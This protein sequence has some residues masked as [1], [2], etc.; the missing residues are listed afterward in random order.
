MINASELTGHRIG[1]RRLTVT[2]T[3]HQLPPHLW[4]YAYEI[5][6]PQP[7]KR[8]DRIRALLEGENMAAL[9]GASIWAGRLVLEKKITHI[10]ITSD[11]PGRDRDINGQLDTELERLKAVFSVTEPVEIQSSGEPLRERST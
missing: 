7:S 9:H 10:L 1:N 5:V 6:P 11:T 4:V 3:H 8:L 2:G